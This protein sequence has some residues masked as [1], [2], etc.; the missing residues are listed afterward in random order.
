M[1]S[2]PQKKR[3][4]LALSCDNCR[5]KK[6][7]CDRN[8]PCSNCVKLSI[9][10][11][12][13]YSS[14]DHVNHSKTIEPKGSLPNGNYEKSSIHTELALLKSKLKQLE[15][16]VSSGNDKINTMLEPR[17]IFKN[18]L[19][20]E[21]DNMIV[22]SNRDILVGILPHDQ[23]DEEINMHFDGDSTASSRISKSPLPFLLL[24]KKDPGMKFFWLFKKQSSHGEF[25]AKK[26]YFKRPR[27]MS[28]EKYEVIKL[29]AKDKYG[30]GYIKQFEDGFRMREVKDST[31]QFGH[32]LGITFH[33]VDSTNMTLEQRIITYMP[34][35]VASCKYLAA[36]FEYL[37]PHFPIIDEMSFRS[38]L[39][40]I[41]GPSEG[42]VKPKIISV[43]KKT[44]Y[45]IIAIYFYI[46]RLAS[47]LWFNNDSSNEYHL[48]SDDSPP[49]LQERQ[50]ALNNPITLD[51]IAVAQECLN[52]FNLAKKPEIAVLQAHMFSRIYNKYSPE[53]G[54]NILSPEPQIFNGILA[55]MAFAL[56]LN[57]DPDYYDEMNTDRVKN[58]RRKIWHVLLAMDIEDCMVFGTAQ[59]IEGLH[60]YD[61]KLPYYT[62]GCEN[63]VD[64]ELEKDVIKSFSLLRPLILSSFDITK[65]VLDVKHKSG[66]SVILDEIKD[67]EM[68]CVRIFGRLKNFLKP[69]LYFSDS[70]V[71]KQ[72]SCY[73]RIKLFL[74]NMYFYFY[75]HY[76]NKGKTDLEFFYLKKTLTTLF[77]ELAEISDL[78][79]RSNSKVF[80]RAFTLIL[81]PV[82]T[83]LTHACCL[84]STSLC[85]RLTAS[86]RVDMTRS[87][88]NSSK[89]ILQE[90]LVLTLRSSQHFMSE[91]GSISSR[92]LYAWKIHKT[93]WY[94][95]TLMDEVPMY[96]SNVSITQTAQ[97]SFSNEQLRELERILRNHA[98]VARLPTTEGSFPPLDILESYKVLTPG[99]LDYIKADGLDEDKLIY[100]FQLNSFWC[101]LLQIGT[102]AEYD[103]MS[104]LRN[105]KKNNGFALN[106]PRSDI[107]DG[108]NING[109]IN[110]ETAD[111]YNEVSLFDLFNF[112]S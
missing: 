83:Y 102:E 41:M 7:K 31:S 64:I 97:L 14:P 30:D 78:T 47:L 99:S 96:E 62:D 93:L 88:V 28:D 103:Y 15:N 12:C 77:Y 71:I 17:K 61:T 106:T 51:A 13:T 105:E 80:G 79:T 18:D 38:D 68:V 101:M 33:P 29:K 85:V 86:L 81:T 94:G 73:L 46:V 111:I 45:A 40:R 92:Y 37:Y 108:S 19:Y 43:S 98:V 26:L 22:K 87:G 82:L 107:L 48:V 3:K 104:F 44:D 72:V 60:N 23:T 25:S 52:V 16:S 91:L 110:L 50:I 112:T 20:I 59:S 57:R 4:R 36:F 27:N 70:F 109:L 95:M 9:P 89:E 67:L 6:T 65:R 42:N 5:K 84:V 49:Y 56:K 32:R 24:S 75:I 11:T 69:E 1:M 66:V 2:E 100:E 53:V 10:H 76:H 55:H 74:V 54:D 39:A 58:L 8:L 21:S 63:I 35:S 90:L 34:E